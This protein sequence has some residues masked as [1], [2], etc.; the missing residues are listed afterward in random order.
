[1]V[2]ISAEPGIC[3]P[4][5]EFTGQKGIGDVFLRTIMNRNFDFFLRDNFIRRDKSGPLIPTPIGLPK[6]FSGCPPC[7]FVDFVSLVRLCDSQNLI[8]EF[9]L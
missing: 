5:R 2:P 9:L 1:M 7:R 6:E 4:F 8:L 3:T